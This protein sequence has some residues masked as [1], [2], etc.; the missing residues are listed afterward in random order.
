MVRKTFTILLREIRDLHEAAYVLAFFALGSQLLALARDRLLA[1]TFGAG[2]ELDVYYAAFRV[3]DLLFSLFAA[4]LSV[5]VLVPFV[6]DRML[7]SAA[8]ARAVLSAA[9]TWFLF[10]FGASALVV[11]VF[12]R[13]L[14]EFFFPGFGVLERELLVP[15]MRILLAQALL[16]SISSL[17]G[18][19]VQLHRK[20]ILYAVSPLLYNLGIIFGIVALYPLWGLAGLALGAGLGALAHLAVQA[21]FVFHSGLLPR[22][23]LR[24]EKGLL[25]AILRVSLPRTLALSLQSG[26]LLVFSAIASVM[27]A[28]SLSV[29]QFA[30]NVQS[31]PLAVIGVSYSVAAFP[32][33]SRLYSRG[34]RSAFLAQVSAALR[35]LLFWA[36]PAAGLCIV[37]RAQIVRV[38]LG[39]GLFDWND[40]RLVAAALALFVVSL[41]GQA[42]HLLVVRAFYAAGETRAPLVVTLCASL[43]AVGAAVALYRW[44]ERSPLFAGWLGALLRVADIPGAELLT[45]PL[46]FSLASII[47]SVVLVALFARAYRMPCAPLF[48]ASARALAAAF[49]AAASAYAAQNALVSGFR[50]ETLA[51]IFLQGLL[52]GIAGIAA[53]WVLLAS[54][55]SRE[56][57]EI[58]A[59]LS[60]NWRSRFISARPIAPE[61]QDEPS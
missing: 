45:L 47:S 10:G 25:R 28:G 50:T 1:H 55:Q 51:G 32:T 43:G 31:V 6:A 41:A 8:R 53:G 14:A 24:I 54:A 19:A 37:L 4:M 3:P 42:I 40:T 11:F 39:S 9:F 61:A 26:V 44:Y 18:V 2:T 16:L 27:T 49:V 59:A 34:N 21:P 30:Y 36:V 22:V 29:L 60:A 57:A 48:A 58:R 5:Y 52:S 56:L 15:L 17:F 46:G 7:E 38:A 23:T 12:A 35:H 33:L 13:P 20:F